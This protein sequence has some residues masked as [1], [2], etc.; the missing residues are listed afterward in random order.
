MWSVISMMEPGRISGFRLP[1][2]LVR[3]SVSIPA[4]F[5]I[6]IAGRMTA[7]L[8]DLIRVRAA[9]QHGDFLAAELPDEELARMAGNLRRRESPEAP[10]TE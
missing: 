7:A 10:Y 3:I 9:R 5:S 8:P 1:A 6:S 2:A 4:P